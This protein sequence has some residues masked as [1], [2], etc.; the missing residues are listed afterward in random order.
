MREA[1]GNLWD[2]YDQGSWV[3]ITTNGFVKRNGE[4]VMGAGVAKQCKERYPDFPRM[5]GSSIRKLG[6]RL[7]VWPELRI[8]TFPVKHNWWETADLQLI[9]LSAGQLLQQLDENMFIAEP[10]YLPRPGCLNGGLDWATEVK[11]ILLPIL[12]DRVIVVDR[13]P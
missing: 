11:P 10:V 8:V 5:L 7:L 1:F 6:N 9:E 13:S 2:W 3:C 12:D 4:N